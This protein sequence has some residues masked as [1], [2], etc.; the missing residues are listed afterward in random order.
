MEYARKLLLTLESQSTNARPASSGTRSTLSSISAQKQRIRRLNECLHLSS[1]TPSSSEDSDSDNDD[2][3]GVDGLEEKEN[4]K[5]TL[6]LPTPSATTAAPAA[7]TANTQLSSTL[8]NRFATSSQQRAELFQG[9]T[10]TNEKEAEQ[11]LD[12]H[13]RE[14]EELTADMLTLASALKESSVRFGAEL[15]QEKGLLDVAKEGLDKNALGIEATGRK[16]DNLRKNESIGY[17]WS[18][19]YPII[20]IGLVSFTPPFYSTLT[21]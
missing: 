7:V 3:D 20:I 9:A 5:S 15:E 6:D 18:I 10:A 1:A 19:L 12:L 8:R 16:M 11:Q 14:Q 4:V 2:D 21:E 17:M 13:H